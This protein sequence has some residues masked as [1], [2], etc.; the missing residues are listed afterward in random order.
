M[1]G[2]EMLVCIL[3]VVI[4]TGSTNTIAKDCSKI[5]CPFV[6]HC[7]RRYTPP[8]ECCSKCDCRKQK[9]GETFGY[10]W[11][12]QKQPCKMCVCEGGEEI[13]HKFVCP[14]HKLFKSCTKPNYNF[15]CGCKT[16]CQLGGGILPTFP[17]IPN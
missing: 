15:Y 4:A 3:L 6:T 5:N 1:K 17:P 12:L 13:C 2:I 9:V 8:G 11:L 10:F 7:A 16:S 14:D